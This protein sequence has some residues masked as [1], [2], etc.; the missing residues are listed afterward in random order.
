MFPLSHPLLIVCPLQEKN[1]RFEQ[2]MGQSCVPEITTLQ[3]SPLSD[4]IKS[5]EF[6]KKKI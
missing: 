1:S 3:I 5:R 6:K 2:Q 4:I